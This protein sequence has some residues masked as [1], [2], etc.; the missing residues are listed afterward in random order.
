MMPLLL[1]G[2][3]V[4]LDGRPL[5]A[6]LTFTVPPG[7]VVTVLG[8][9]GSGKSSL[10][11]HLAGVLPPT[12]GASGQVRLGSQPLDGR[13]PEERRLGLLF[14]DPLL[15]PHLSV[16]ANLAFGLREPVHG[17]AARR[18]IVAQALGAFDLEGF[19]DRDP[20][21]LSGGQQARVALL[22]VLL[23]GPRALLL[24]EPFGRLDAAT[25]EMTRARVFAE[26]RERAL[27]ALLVTHDAADAAA[28]AG[29]VVT[30]Q[31]A[32]GG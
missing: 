27:P 16:G 24:D 8:P 7:V 23:S 4:V 15:F 17:R 21:T 14:Q 29:P 32:R 28:A 18:Q 13:P 31:P 2:V 6:P 9:S 25:R 10:L 22:R 3:T 11:A 5:F 12:L 30:L 20:A 26:V 1:E 19:A